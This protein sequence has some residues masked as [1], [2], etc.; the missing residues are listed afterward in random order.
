MTV[1]SGDRATLRKQF[2]EVAADLWMLLAEVTDADWNRGN[3]GTRWTVGELVF[4]VYSGVLEFLPREIA[5]ARAGKDFLNPPAFLNPIAEPLAF[6]VGRFMARNASLGAFRQRFQG[7][8]AAALGAFDSITDD[9][10][11]RG[12]HFYGEGFRSMEDLVRLRR[13]HF[14]EHAAQIRRAL[15][16]K[17]AV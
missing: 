8:L 2:E 1:G 17:S 15:K 3:T 10:W 4:H 14:N 13:P 12:A 11:G 7:D 5:A 6:I 9:E 16:R